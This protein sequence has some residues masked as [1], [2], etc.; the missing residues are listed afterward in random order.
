[1]PLDG[2][3]IRALVEEL[4]DRLD[5]R[6]P[7]HLV[8]VAGGSLLAWHG[9]R[10][11]TRDVDSLRPLDPELAG[12]VAEVAA[13]HG[14]GPDWLNAHAAAFAPATLDLAAC[15]VLL[16]TPRLRV[17]G[18][19][20]DQVFLMRLLAARD[21]D[22]DD[23]RAPWPHTGFSSA[24]QAAEQC[25]RAYPHAPDDPYFADFVAQFTE[26]GG[27]DQDRLPRNRPPR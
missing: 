17:L 19:P 4:A 13:A 7:Q 22:I 15:R 3:T 8:V 11:S 9:L 25:W 1:M 27:P 5:P 12:A 18:A 21:R 2:A 14:L 23:L 10:D 20:L 6:G 26:H 16:E 24:Q